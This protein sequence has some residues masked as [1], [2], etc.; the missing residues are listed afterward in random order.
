MKRASGQGSSVGAEQK[1]LH[2]EQWQTQTQAAVEWFHN[3]HCLMPVRCLDW[4]T[5]WKVWLHKEI[6]QTGGSVPIS[7]LYD[8]SLRHA[9]SQ[10][11]S[12]CHNWHQQASVCKPK[13]WR[14]VRYTKHLRNICPVLQMIDGLCTTLNLNQSTQ[15]VSSTYSPLEFRVHPADFQSNHELLWRNQF[16]SHM[17][18]LWQSSL[19]VL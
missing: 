14:N 10:V 13:H 12:S 4:N 5:S 8:H 18:T 2:S 3:L 16:G 7:C 11:M 1:K 9:L 19:H 17:S 6:S 15:D